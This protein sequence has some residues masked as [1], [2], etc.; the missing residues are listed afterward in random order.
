MRMFTRA[1]VVF[2]LVAA[3][4]V[5]ALL[6]PLALSAADEARGLDFYFIDTEGGAATLLVTPAGESVLIDSGNP[7]DRD[8]HRIAAAAHDAG[9]TEIDHYITTH[10]HSDHVGGAAPLSKLLPIK[11]RYG[12][13]IPS[14][15]PDDINAQLV[16]AWKGLAGEPQFLVAG[17]SLKLGRQR[18]AP[19]VRLN[20]L[21]AD[22]LVAG[23]K[24]GAPQIT[25]CDDGNKPRDEDTSDNARSLAMLITFGQ[26]KLFAGGDLTWNVE[27][28]L[29]CPKKLV[30]RVD[31]YLADHHGLDLSN[32]PSLVSAL[33]PEVAIVN[34]GARK[35]AEPETM[36]L[37][38]SLVGEVGVFQL[39][40]NVRPG[41][42]NTDPARIANADETCGGAY[43]RLRVDRGGE[44]YTVEVP[45][46]ETVRHY[47]TR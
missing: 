31:V 24:P 33:A 14:P 5:T 17:D 47:D 20:V 18:G 25:T 32:N 21:A 11:A 13:A 44:H 22:G 15:L 40:R 45:S 34:S 42:R 35:G 30:P 46:R 7:G 1:R 41:A 8:A 37:L 29:V 9:I 43:I 2:V 6:A 26:F 3:L 39:H 36:K 10:W 23:E 16:D 12:H 38:L 4:G 19:D 28:K 27:H